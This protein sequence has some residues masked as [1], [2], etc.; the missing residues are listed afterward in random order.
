MIFFGFC[1]GGQNP[2]ISTP[3]KYATNMTYITRLLCSRKNTFNN[4][5]RYYMMLESGLDTMFFSIGKLYEKY[6]LIF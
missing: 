5:Y 2:G 4:T 3:N 6:F 1:E